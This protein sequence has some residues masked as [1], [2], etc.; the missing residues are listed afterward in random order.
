MLGKDKKK[1]WHLQIF[2]RF[3]YF[4][5]QNWAASVQFDSLTVLFSSTLL[6]LIFLY[7]I[8]NIYIIY[9]I[10]IFF[11][12]R[13]T[14]KINCQTVKL[15]RLYRFTPLGTVWQFDSCFW[16]HNI[17]S[18]SQ[19]CKICALTDQQN[20]PNWGRFVGEPEMLNYINQ[21]KLIMQFIA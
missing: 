14:P 19:Q 11:Q 18:T 5:P 17:K 8:Y 16:N 13:G 4:M 10:I 6:T 7:S 21:R 15:Y 9:R 2:G 1:K 3:F 20:F 12:K